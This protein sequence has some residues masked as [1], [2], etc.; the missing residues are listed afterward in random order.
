MTELLEKAVQTARSL[1]VEQQDDLAR[2]ILTYAGHDEPVIELTQEEE[3]DL[4]E[5]Q[6]EMRRGEFASDAE[7]E[8]V[9]SKFRL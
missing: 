4:I 2:M 1:P 6:A 5:A 3:V 7:V 9:L 8:A